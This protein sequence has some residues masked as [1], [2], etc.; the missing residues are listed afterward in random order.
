MKGLIH[1]VDVPIY[2]QRV[3]V[4]FDIET[5]IRRFNI[6]PQNQPDGFAAQVHDGVD[7]AFLMCI[8]QK[9]G[10]LHIGITSH[11]CYHIAD[12]IFEKCGVEYKFDS[13]NEHMAYLLDWLVER[14]FDC[15][16][17][18]KKFLERGKEEYE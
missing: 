16:D 9:D 11:E 8:P 2:S 12:M 10:Y 1:K 7:M 14:T 18:E 17:V 6:E 13:G 4:C 3:Y 15:L 5:A